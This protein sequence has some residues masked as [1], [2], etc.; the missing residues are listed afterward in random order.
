MIIIAVDP[1]LTGAL[2]RID[3]DGKLFALEDMPVMLRGTATKIKNQVNCSALAD[4][5]RSWIAGRD[6][7]EIMVYIE[8]V[9]A[10]PGQGV[11]SMFSLGHT[12]G[13]IEG[14]V[15]ALGLAHKLIPAATWKKAMKVGKDKDQG[16]AVAQR[17]FPSAELHL[18]KHH[19][20]GESLLLAVYGQTQES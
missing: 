2:C 9:A 17:L 13:A 20:R 4:M 7:N 8:R 6:K 14:V 3:H 15:S 1:G 16:R 10:M 5:L 11:S 12:S 18:K 19:N